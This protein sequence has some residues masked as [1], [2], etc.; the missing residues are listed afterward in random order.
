[1]PPPLLYQ[2]LTI[3]S[4][5]AITTFSQ[6]AS[7][8]SN[9]E[10]LTSFLA[11]PAE[12][13]SP[14]VVVLSLSAIAVKS[15]SFRFKG[16]KRILYDKFTTLFMENHLYLITGANGI[17][18][19][20]IIRIITGCL[21][22][23]ADCIYVN[24]SHE[25]KQLDLDSYRSFMHY[26]PQTPYIIKGTIAENIRLANLGNDMIL[27]LIMNMD[28]VKNQLNSIGGLSRGIDSDSQLS[29]GEK[30]FISLLQMVFHAKRWVFLD[31]PFSAMDE[32]MRALS[33][34][35]ITEYKKLL[36]ASIIIISHVIPAI[37]IDQVINIQ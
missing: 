36:N 24:N 14:G 21:Q 29:G 30:Q 33:C 6:I 34:R 3:I 35:I 4:I 5:K 19:S 11:L 23:D 31:E 28:S 25:I 32:R 8:D 26:A 2:Y 27:E 7:V 1:M 9:I 10:K 15:L 13:N 12:I 37:D 20:T 17:G 22:N 18:K 16:D